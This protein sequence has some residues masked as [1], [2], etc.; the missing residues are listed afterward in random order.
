M[1]NSLNYNFPFRWYVACLLAIGCALSVSSQTV[2][3]VIDSEDSEPVPYATVMSRTG[4]IIGLTDNDGT[5]SISDADRFP[6]TIKCM[7]YDPLECDKATTT[8]ALTHSVYPLGEVVVSPAERPVTHLICYI[9]EYVS[10]ESGADAMIMF[11]EHM[12][13]FFVG[14]SKLKGIKTMDSPRFLTSRLRTRVTN[15]E[16]N[17]DTIFV[18]KSRNEM[19]AWEQLISIPKERMELKAG[20]VNGKH[21]IK[22]TVRHDG[23]LATIRADYLA[24]AKDH[25]MSPWFFKVIGFTMD[26]TEF[27]S[28][29]IVRPSGTDSYTGADILS[30]T[31]SFDSTGR[32]KWIK[33][34]FRTDNP[35]RMYGYYE[36]YPVEI[37]HLTIEEAKELQ[38]NPPE[39]RMKVSPLAPA[40]ESAAQLMIDRCGK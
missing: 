14:D 30:A 34:A 27:Q 37:E 32:G 13:D 35:V 22:E 4:V 23:D 29:M 11:N 2:I 18:P 15:S 31:F 36:I 9:R 19:I 26:I 33:K 20:T 17:L 12:G 3:R 38:K 8:A 25:S 24:D 6:V 1:K 5:I 40:P 16:Q 10:G 7:G 39:V 28:S 21:G